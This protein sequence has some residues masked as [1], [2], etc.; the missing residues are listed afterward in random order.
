V[1]IAMPMRIWN[2][3]RFIKWLIFGPSVTV[4]PADEDVLNLIGGDIL[5]RRGRLHRDARHQ[6]DR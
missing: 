4:D 1:L 2:L 3:F 5:E 6:S